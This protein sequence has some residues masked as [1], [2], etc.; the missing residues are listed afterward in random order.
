[1]EK[2][3][4]ARIKINKLLEESG[5]RLIDTSKGR[6]NV[7]LEPNIDIKDLDDNFEKI[8]KGYVDYLL[9]DNENFPICILEAKSEDKDPLVGK[10][11]ARRYA[12]AENVRFIILSNGNTHYFWDKKLGNPTKILRFP[13]LENFRSRKEFIPDVEKL[14]NLEIKDD[15][16]VQTQ[17]PVYSS[18]PSYID[19]STRTDFIRDRGLKF[20]RPYQL[21]AVRSIQ[22]SCRKGKN[23]FLLEMATGTGKT[24]ISAAVIKLYLKSKN[25][26][27]I[28]FLVDRLELEDQAKK[29][30]KQYLYPDY[31]SVIYKEKRDD[32]RKA[33]IVVTTI[34]S[35]SHDNKYLKLFSPNDFDLIIS[36]EAHRSISGNSRQIFEYFIGAKLGL[37]ATPKDYLK[38]LQNDFVQRFVGM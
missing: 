16:I 22:S 5:W 19:P 32:W 7:I 33:H 29:N 1:M 24:L 12:N 4:K 35:I 6:A 38:N 27:R 11:Q 18:D 2:E 17:Y 13:S 36:D 28:L 3:A 23:R 34:Q 20:L 8:K 31:I 15:F 37:T 30:F 26:N 9:L 25:A 14:I 10:E 21:D